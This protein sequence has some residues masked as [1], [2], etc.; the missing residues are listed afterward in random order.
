[1]K[2]LEY[3]FNPD[4][5]IKNGRK[6]KKRL[7][8]EGNSFIE[9]RIAILGGSTTS[10]VKDML[11]LF[12]LNYGIKPSF[13]ESEYNKF[14]ED[15]MFDNPALEEFKP[16]VIYIHTTSVNIDTFPKATDDAETAGKLKEEVFF[17]YKSLWESIGERY[18]CPIIQNN[19]EPPKYRL[20]GNSDCVMP[21]GAVNF[22]NGL[23]AKFADYAY[24]H[25]NLYIH[26]IN[27]EASC[28]GLDKWADPSYWYMYKYAM[29]LNA[30]PGCAYGV[31]LIIKSLFGKNKKALSL[32]LDNTL[33]GGVIGDDGPENI[34][35]GQETPMAQAY[36]AF[37]AYLKRQSEIG[38]VLT[39]NSKNNDDVARK[40][41]ERADSVLKLEDFASF[42]ANW[43]N[44]D[45]NLIKTAD[46]LKLLPE[47]FVFADDNP[48]ERGLVASNV[49]GVAVPE[50]DG[51]E[52]YIRILDRSGFFEVTALTKDDADRARM[53]RENA[54]RSSEMARFSDYGSYLK[55]LDMKAEITSFAPEYM[56]RIAQLTNKSNQFNLTTL[57]LTRAEIE[58]MAAD[59][60]YITLYGKLTDKFGD[61]GVVSVAIG[62]ITGDTVDIILWL[63]SCRVLKRDMEYAMMGEFVKEARA[64]GIKKINGHYY[65]T[66][67]NAMVKD[68]YSLHG[69]VKESEDETGNA[70]WVINTAD[71]KAKEHSIAINA[72]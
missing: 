70:L 11:E 58:S 25:K 49:K 65:P 63:M 29:G 56:E 21:G 23:N 22:I 14:F 44:K 27:Y 61:N 7:L 60:E 28:Y 48:A 64:R 40:G 54:I 51:V 20:L 52:N 34:E 12:L 53:Y 71:Y 69:F 33:W 19:F 62:K 18:G 39:V 57:R 2:E 42:Y 15:G 55:S 43:D 67:K 26:D 3:P 47:S 32:D 59:K 4:Y 5:L 37:Q 9:K 30:I 38:V 66:A 36:S 50:M 35:V 46:E 10:A 68:F 1:M 6:L 31:A 45:L 8:E 72:R 17:K 41:F 16:D 13:Y 24:T